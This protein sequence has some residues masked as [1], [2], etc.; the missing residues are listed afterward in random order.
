MREH[1]VCEYH[2]GNLFSKTNVLIVLLRVESLARRDIKKM[3]KI[4]QDV[5]ML[6]Q[7]GMKRMLFESYRSHGGDQD[8]KKIILRL[9]QEMLAC[10]HGL[11]S[12]QFCS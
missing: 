12:M 2:C 4:M 7:G 11:F 6:V 8:G 3:P 10:E 5:L 9:W 1:T